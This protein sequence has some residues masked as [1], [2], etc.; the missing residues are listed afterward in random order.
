LNGKKYIDP[1]IM[2]KQAL[3]LQDKL[4][5][6]NV[7]AAM[8]GGIAIWNI[9]QGQRNWFL[10]NNRKY[11]DVDFVGYSKDFYII[12]EIFNSVGY[13][14]LENPTFNI[15]NKAEFSNNSISVDFYFDKLEFNHKIDFSKGDI[16][17][18]TKTINPSVLLLTKLQ[19]VDLKLNHFD[20]LDSLA[21]LS[22]VNYS[23]SQLFS[24]LFKELKNNYFFYKTVLNNLSYLLTK[25]DGISKLEESIKKLI[26]N[27]QNQKKSLRWHIYKYLY[28]DNIKFNK[29]N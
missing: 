17:R 25:T 7:Y 2:L 4:I 12:K 6:Q 14:L 26:H 5:E 1:E 11:K 21:L 29:I 15:Y 23:D 20:K 18:A 28:N 19:N 8:F 10:K 16:H 24:R 9:C 27:L 3:F 22:E 13:D